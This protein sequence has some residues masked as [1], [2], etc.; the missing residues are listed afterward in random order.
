MTHGY[1]AIG[2]GPNDIETN[3]EAMGVH[4]QRAAERSPTNDAGFQTKDRQNRSR[5]DS[6]KQ[7]ASVCRQNWTLSWT[8]NGTT[9]EVAEAR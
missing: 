8:T 3:T 6:V 4:P 7:S 9:E 2:F 5:Q 1:G